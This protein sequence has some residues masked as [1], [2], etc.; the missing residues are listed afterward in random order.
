MINQVQIRQRKE[1]KKI[2]DGEW[3]YPPGQNDP[4]GGTLRPGRRPD[5]APHDGPRG[6]TY[7][8]P[9]RFERRAQTPILPGKERKAG[10]AP[11]SSLGLIL[12]LC[13]GG[14][15][16]L[17]GAIFGFILLN[18]SEGDQQG[19]D[20]QAFKRDDENTKQEQ[21]KIGKDDKG[22]DEK[23]KGQKLVP[24]PFKPK[25]EAGDHFLRGAILAT[26]F[27][28]PVN[29]SFCKVYT[30]PMAAARL[31]SLELASRDFVPY[32]RLEDSD[33][34]VVS[35]NSNHP[36]VRIDH[37]PAKAG[38]YRLVIGTRNKDNLYPR[39]K[40]G[41]FFLHVRGTRPGEKGPHLE[42]DQGKMLLPALPKLADIALPSSQLVK[43]HLEAKK[44]MAPPL[45]VRRI[46][47]PVS[48]FRKILW[49]AD[50]KAFFLV[51][52]N[53][54]LQRI[55]LAGLVEE[56]RLATNRRAPRMALS[57]EGL[58]LTFANE[59]ELWVV[60]ADR[61]EV[62][63]RIALPE[64]VADT[65]SAAN[66]SV[67]IVQR[68][69]GF[70]GSGQ[71][72]LLDLKK[73][74][75]VLPYGIDHEL[76]AVSPDGKYVF[77]RRDLALYRHRLK[78]GKLTLEE[79]SP[80]F[81]N[82]HPVKKILFSP[83][84]AYVCLPSG[85]GN[86]LAGFPG[87]KKASVYL[88]RCNDLRLPVGVIPRGEFFHVYGLDDKAKQA[89]TYQ[90]PNLRVYDLQ[91][92][93]KGEFRLGE[94]GQSISEI[95]VHPDGHKLLLL[96]HQGLYYV[97]LPKDDAKQDPRGGSAATNGFSWAVAMR[98]KLGPLTARLAASAWEIRM[99][100]LP[101]LR[102]LELNCRCPNPPPYPPRPRPFASSPPPTRL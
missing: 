25:R 47:L 51:D 15:V 12:G 29:R 97:E 11:Q 21:K 60:D 44:I 34:K 37:T 18:R 20:K 72:L 85:G 67:G 27:Q 89:Y 43:R 73:G 4:D 94:A 40:T 71:I 53:G 95:V 77:T 65:V 100:W 5:Q 86:A 49:S 66:L 102:Y 78:D 75:F 62:K 30:F 70:L 82:I 46:D 52:E 38:V 16:L 92:N 81:V 13:G 7:S 64:A 50:G 48:A 55:L 88:F 79:R 54:L 76:A 91:G 90:N 58:L 32:L 80:N 42:P 41:A 9:E 24:D 101:G 45:M 39:D 63:K 28:E 98:G 31:Y 59:K 68:D 14:V 22:K 3:D 1:F 17:A 99:G 26:D 57:A 69:T 2:Q 61:L 93:K 84:G 19:K 87:H 36:S 23:K 8:E 35:F 10:P 74:E 96:I 33:H 56:R 6:E 83:G